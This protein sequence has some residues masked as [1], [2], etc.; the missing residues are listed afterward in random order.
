MAVSHAQK[1]INKS[2]HDAAARQ[3]N[4][5]LF[6]NERGNERERDTDRGRANVC[7]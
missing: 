1:Q 3:Q 6:D 5:I 2:V 4:V 7:N